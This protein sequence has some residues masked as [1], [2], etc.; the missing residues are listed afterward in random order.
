M[1]KRRTTRR[2]P[3]RGVEIDLRGGKQA[4]IW[5]RVKNRAPG[6]FTGS[7]MKIV[8]SLISAYVIKQL[9]I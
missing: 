9:G 6:L 1:Q 4:E 2:C 5:K 7:A 8:Q 3:G